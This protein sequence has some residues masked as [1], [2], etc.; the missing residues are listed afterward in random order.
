MGRGVD[1]LQ[2][3]PW[4]INNGLL[5]EGGTVKATITITIADTPSADYVDLGKAKFI[6]TG[7]KEAR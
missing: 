4:G 5:A 2:A 6:F 7:R 1:E 3:T